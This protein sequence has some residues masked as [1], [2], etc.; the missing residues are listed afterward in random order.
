MK[1]RESSREK[2]PQPSHSGERVKN[3]RE[4]L[5]Y[6]GLA[7][8]FLLLPAPLCGKTLAK[9]AVRQNI[10][11]PPGAVMEHL[12]PGRC[13][14]C[15][16]CAEVCPFHCIKL[17]DIRSGFHAGT[18][19]V[20]VK[21]RPCYL[22]MKCVHVCPTGALQPIEQHRTRMGV[23]V[24]DRHSCVS[25]QQSGLLCKTCFNVCPFINKAIRMVEFRPHIDPRDCT[26]CG[27][28]THA[29]LV[30]RPDGSKAVNISPAYSIINLPEVEG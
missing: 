24:I 22:C 18:P 28:C 16:R 21:E 8:G 20:K 5:R 17:L 12:Y 4:I 23:A 11:R 7:A 6:F 30:E 10:L 3:R 19:V 26:G 2:L 14:R 15:G 25:W 27:I 13:I 9:P 1:L 29:C